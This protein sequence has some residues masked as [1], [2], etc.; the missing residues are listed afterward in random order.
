MHH[1]LPA[2]QADAHRPPEARRRQRRDR[3][4]GVGLHFLA[5]EGAAHAQAL[6]DDRVLRHAEHARDDLLRLGRVLRRRVDEHAAVLV[7]IRERG[8]GLEIEVLL[9]A[10]RELAVEAVRRGA[11]RRR[12]IALGAGDRRR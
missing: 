7:A 4:P 6:H 11:Q 9:P 10:D 12:G 8:V 3:R 5:A 1:V 2:R